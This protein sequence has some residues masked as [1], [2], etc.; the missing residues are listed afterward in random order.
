MGVVD[1]VLVPY[2]DSH[3]PVEPAKPKQQKKLLKNSKIVDQL[4]LNLLDLDEYLDRKQ[5]EEN[6]EKHYKIEWRS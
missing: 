1:D 2:A 4:S 3:D 6:W 5:E